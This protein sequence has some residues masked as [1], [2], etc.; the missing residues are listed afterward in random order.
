VLLWN[1]PELH[2]SM[3]GEF[4]TADDAI[5]ADRREPGGVT[6]RSET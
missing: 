3:Y 1:G 2:L 4:V 6:E 5:R